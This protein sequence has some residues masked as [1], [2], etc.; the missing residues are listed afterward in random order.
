MSQQQGVS[1]GSSDNIVHR[2]VELTPARRGYINGLRD[3]GTSIRAIAA[4][5]GIPKSTISD[6]INQTVNRIDERSQPRQGR[7]SVYTQRDIRAI[8]RIIQKDPKIT[9][10]D[11]IKRLATPLSRTT[12]KK[13]IRQLGYHKWRAV[14]PASGPTNS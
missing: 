7:N 5:T 9:Y 13:I 1:T 14:G 3:A 2:G 6:T 4:A 8:K 10:T 12:V 11:L